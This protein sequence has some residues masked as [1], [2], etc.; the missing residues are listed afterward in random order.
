V[1]ILENLSFSTQALLSVRQ[2]RNKSHPVTYHEGAERAWKYN[3]TFFKISV[4]DGRAGYRQAA[5]ALL[6]EI[7][8]YSF[9][10]RLGGP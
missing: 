5:A 6:T 4:L 2:S 7:T 1:E 3:Y 8:L 10:G 9:Y